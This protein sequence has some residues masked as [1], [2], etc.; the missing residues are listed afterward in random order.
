MRIRENISIGRSVGWTSVAGW[1]CE[2]RRR[3]G[4]EAVLVSV[5]LQG[6]AAL[7]LAV[8]SYSLCRHY[9][10]RSICVQGSSML[11][12]LQERHWYL[13]SPLVFR[14]REPKPGDIVVLR[15]PTD[16]SLVVK[17]VIAV[18]GDTVELRDGRVYVNGHQLQEPYL[19]PDTLTWPVRA[20]WV[21]TTCGAGEYFVLGDNRVVSVDS[22]EYGPVS[23]A[24]LVG[25]VLR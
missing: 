19:P 12:T 3:L 9:L 24:A 5:L 1:W 7:G 4:G 22:R 16:G 23:Q 13:A 21:R 15:D 2:C 11:P 17:R 25:M 10:V 8:G 6:V 18:A 20:Q 14:W